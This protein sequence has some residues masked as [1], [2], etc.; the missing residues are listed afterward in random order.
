MKVARH[1]AEDELIRDAGQV[2]K[3]VR[4]GE[5]IVVEGDGEPRAVIVDPFDL[6]ILGAALGYYLNHPPIAKEAGLT[7][8]CLADLDATSRL[9]RV[10]AHYLA[11]AISLSRAAEL[12]GRPWVDL[13][14]RFSR[15][16]IPI[17]IAPTDEEGARQDVLVALSTLS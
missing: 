17:R 12:L 5:A 2:F 13:R 8:A 6:E 16:G 9:E 14:D 10:V 11:E 7:E 4:G 15:I 3:A 1:I